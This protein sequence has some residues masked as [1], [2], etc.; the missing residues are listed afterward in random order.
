MSSS[1]WARNDRSVSRSPEI[2]SR[3]P[4]RV[5]SASSSA[6][7]ARAAASSAARLSR[8]RELNT[9]RQAIGRRAARLESDRSRRRGDGAANRVP[10]A[11]KG[12]RMA[13][14]RANGSAP[15]RMDSPHSQKPLELILARNLLTSLSTPAFL[16]D[17]D[18]ALVFFNEAA[19]ALL[20]RS[21]EDVG[22]LSAEEWSRDLRPVRRRR[23]AAGGRRAGDDRVDPGRPP[24]PREVLDPGGERRDDADRVERLPADRQRVGARPAR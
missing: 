22:Q 9:A 6:T 24:G 19:A 20:G 2:G 10:I 16:V 21:F 17:S 13:A 7:R 15:D 12:G 14:R 11:A 1:S 3:E 18:A 23:Q 5:T 4:S 8:S